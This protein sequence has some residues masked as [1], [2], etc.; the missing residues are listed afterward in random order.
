MNLQPLENVSAP[1]VSSRTLVLTYTT[2]IKVSEVKAKR[3]SSLVHYLNMSMLHMIIHP[4]ACSLGT[5]VSIF[6]CDHCQ[7]TVNAKLIFF[8]SHCLAE[9][10][11]VLPVAFFVTTK[12][13]C[14]REKGINPY[15]LKS[16]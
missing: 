8:L 5:V 14:D 15:T 11:V 13:R 7:I 3:K 12:H 16:N 2:V 9:R 10:H 6:H 4:F 1:Q